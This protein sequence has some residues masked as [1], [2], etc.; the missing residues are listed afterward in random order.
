MDDVSARLYA[1]RMFSLSPPEPV[2]DLLTPSETA[3]CLNVAEKTLAM[4][5]ST[6]RRPL[7]FVKLGTLVRYRPAD[8]LAFVEGGVRRA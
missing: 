8:V 5:R 6:R 2:E 1:S 4:W 7:P 3:R